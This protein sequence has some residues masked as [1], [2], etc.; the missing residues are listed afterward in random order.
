MAERSGSCGVVKKWYELSFFRLG[1]VRYWGR[2][3]GMT[4]CICS[5]SPSLMSVSDCT[6]GAI[7]SVRGRQW[8]APCVE[9]RRSE[10]GPQTCM[11]FFS[12][13]F[14]GSCHG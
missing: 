9:R 6:F 10:K 13:A 14:I 4:I 2:V 12:A 1:S 7:L 3:L 8:L 11:A 5:G